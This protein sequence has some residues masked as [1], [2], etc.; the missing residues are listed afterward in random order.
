MNTFGVSTS[1]DDKERKKH[2][3]NDNRANAWDVIDAGVVVRD[4]AVNISW[5]AS[6]INKLF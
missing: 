1:S 4:T 3:N 6:I 5:G 2:E